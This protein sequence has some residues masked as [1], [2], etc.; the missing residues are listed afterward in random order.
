VNLH[1][2]RDAINVI[3]R[4]KL[5]IGRDGRNRPSL[6]PY[7]AK[8]GRNAHAKSLF[9]AHA[10]MRSFII[11]PEGVT[12]AYLDWRTQEVGVAA[13][14]SDDRAL[15][16]A[17]NTGDIY[18]AYARDLGLT[19]DPDIAHWKKTEA[20]MRNRMKALNFAITYWMSVKSL[21]KRLDRHELIGSTL[22]LKH[23]LA[24]PRMHEWQ[25]GEVRAAMNT[26][27]IVSGAGW[28]LY[29]SS[30]PNK[31]TLC[32][33]PMQSGGADMLRLGTENMCKA[34]IIPSMLV[35]DA[36]LLETTDPRQIEEARQ[37]ML[38]AGRTVCHGFEIG[39]DV[40]LRDIRPKKTS[41]AIS[42]LPPSLLPRR[43]IGHRRLLPI[44]GLWDN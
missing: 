39:V 4:A 18:Y 13:A 11:F 1:A 19:S 23:K 3:V 10:G 26:R 6:Y 5:P 34:G 21:A 37:I 31:R 33:F 22:I 2:L 15:K 25:D 14:H 40:D 38:A 42:R 41:R 35:H 28:P 8:S 44:T 16:A 7:G 17:Y 29:L 36:I 30:S 12:A 43:I 24:F 20:D 9:N 32:N 27:K